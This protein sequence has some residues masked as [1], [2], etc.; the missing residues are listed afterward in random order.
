[1]LSFCTGS[2]CLCNDAGLQLYLASTEH[3]EL[4]LK[5]PGMREIEKEQ[6]KKMEVCLAFLGWVQCYTV[7]QQNPILSF[8]EDFK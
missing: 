1:M 6:R 2:Q 3:I 5:E 8:T 4:L 7:N